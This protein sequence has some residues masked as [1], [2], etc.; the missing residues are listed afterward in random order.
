[1]N[2]DFLY[3]NIGRG[4]PFYLDG[5][6]EL[7]PPEQVGT[8]TDVFECSRGLSRL[9]WRLARRLYRSGSS[10][11]VFSAF[12]SKVRKAADYSRRTP[13]LHIMGRDIRR[14]F[15][16]AGHPLVVA[17]PSLVG[18]LRGRSNLVYQH[19]ESVVPPECFVQGDHWILV[20]DERVRRAFCD[21]G[22][23]PDRVVVTGLCIEPGLV[24]AAETARKER[25]QRLADRAPLTGVFLS[26]GAEPRL[27]VITLVAAAVS[28]AQRQRRVILLAARD[29]AY[30]RRARGPFGAAGL[31]LT[32]ID[33]PDKLP[34]SPTASLLCLYDSPQALNRF[35]EALFRHF[36]YFVAPPHERTNWAL[37]L[38]LPMYIVDPPIGTFAPLNRRLLLDTGLAGVIRDRQPA[39]GF[40]NML[41]NDL[42][43]GV[44]ERRSEQGAGTFAINGFA[45]GAR[46]LSRQRHCVGAAGGL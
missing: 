22:A 26:S 39:A 10:G 43:N 28:A 6:R 34:A 12:Y 37:G 8:V 18:I 33:S 14:Q 44:L 42:A 1:M 25:Q 27:H 21:A 41:A 20:P 2:I 40:G 19:G 3:A 29:G 16:P 46:F 35:I 38:G 45:E 23:S 24:A 4:H 13:L 17:H 30:A 5:I 36:D 32:G 31:E 9:T 15:A 7:L 11:G